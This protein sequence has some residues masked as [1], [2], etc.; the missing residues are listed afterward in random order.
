MAMRRWIVPLLA[1]CLGFGAAG[2]GAA[3]AQTL[4]D[5]ERIDTNKDNAVS[6]EE[7]EAARRRDFDLLD[8]NK[9]GFLSRD[10]FIN[11]RGADA[12]LVRLRERRFD[13][14]DA[15]RDRRI[16]RAEYLAYG[17]SL[18][19]LLDRDRDG[20]IARAEFEQALAGGATPPPLER[21]SRGPGLRPPAIDPQIR[22]AFVRIDRD[23]DGAVTLAELDAARLG[24]FQQMDTNG[25][26]RLTR[27]EIVAARG[28]A[29]GARFAELDKDKDGFV[30]RREYLE[31]GRAEFRA[32]DTNGDGKLSFEE[33]VRSGSR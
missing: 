9:D 25:D 2:F 16:S 15:D 8:A 32:A 4:A 18:F 23:R 33:F 10:E 14:I 17:R 30:G 28:A 29:A 7:F 21:P 22:A 11:Q 13:Q 19:T 5:F 31:A 6:L 20:R 26:G 1:A 27:D 24:T 12:N 3:E